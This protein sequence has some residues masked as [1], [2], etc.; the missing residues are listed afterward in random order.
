MANLGQKLNDIILPAALGCLIYFAQ[1]TASDLR[2]IAVDLATVT[3]QLGD[4][5]RRI[6]RL[7]LGR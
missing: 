4:M 7:E 6:Q 3:A 5:E 2:K 1:S